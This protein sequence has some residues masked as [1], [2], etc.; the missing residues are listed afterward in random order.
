MDETSTALAYDIVSDSV[1]TPR[2][3]DELL[4]PENADAVLLATTTTVSRP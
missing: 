3:T 4:L 1:A 2:I